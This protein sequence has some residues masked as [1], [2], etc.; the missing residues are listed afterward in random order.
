MKLALLFPGQGA[1][2]AGF[3]HALPEHGAAQEVL[4]EASALLGRDVL[5]LDSESA[6]ASTVATQI[7]LV[8]AGAAFVR[9][10]EAA[11]VGPTIVAGMSVGAYAAAIAAGSID[12]STALTLVRRRAELMEA[13]FPAGTYG[14]AVVEGLRSSAVA[15][16]LGGTQVAIANYNSGSQHVV[17]GR[18]AELELLL[19]RALDAGAHSAKMLRMS[20]ASHTPALLPAAQQLLE[21]A[22]ALPFVQPRV[23]MISN[24]T[25]RAL[26]TPNAIREELALNMAFPVRWHDT[27]TALNAVGVTLLIESPP[28]HTLTRLATAILPDVPSL[29]AGETRWDVI[30][31]TV[32]QA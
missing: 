17:G 29:A 28:G 18:L 3:L 19:P 22:Q 31:R 21:M 1:Q 13:A 2:A 14:M 26:T 11:D 8:V 5:E 27:V 24:R 12:L 9:C 30:L 23:P 4:E 25:A 6:L 32:R 7:A 16:L 20:V 15:G 10:C